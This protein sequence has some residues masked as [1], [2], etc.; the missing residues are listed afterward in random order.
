MAVELAG[1]IMQSK[2]STADHTRLI[3]EAMAKFPSPV[4]T[5]LS[6]DP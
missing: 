2:L 5:S 1:K 6:G 4:P 3:Q